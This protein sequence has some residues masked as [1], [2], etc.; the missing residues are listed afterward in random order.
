MSVTRHSWR[1]WTIG[2]VGAA[3]LGG[4]L[5]GCGS[6]SAT[7][8]PVSIRQLAIALPPQVSL[9]W[10]PPIVPVTACYDVNGGGWFGPD[11]YK[12]LVW[13]NPND[14]IDYARSLASGISVNRNDT[15]FT[16]TLNPKWHW[17]NGQ[18]VT[19]ADAA[20]D[21]QLILA[22]SGSK[23]PWAY[24]FAGS[25][26]VPGDWK[27]VHVT[28]LY[29]FSITTT[30][31]VNPAWFEHNGLGQIVPVPK[32]TWERYANP[33]QELNW[34]KSVSATWSNRVYDVYDGPYHIV[35]GV[36]S[37]YWLY[38][39]N[40]HYDG[41]HQPTFR[42][43]RYYYETSEASTFL[44]L[45]KKT[46]ELATAPSSYLGALKKMTDY[47]IVAPPLFGYQWLGLNYRRT[48]LDVGP[49]FNNLYI[50]QAL[51]MGIDQA[52]II[53]L[54]GGY[55]TPV[56]GPVPRFPHNI[57]YDYRLPDYYPYNPARGKALLESHGWHEVNGVM[58]KNG[59][60][61][62]FPILDQSGAGSP[63][64]QDE[65]EI[66]QAGWAKE[67]IKATIYLSALPANDG[68][69]WAVSGF[70]TWVYAPDF[71]P[72]GGSL[73]A[74]TGGVNLSGGDYRSAEMDHL[75][76]ATYAPGSEAQTI[77]RFYAYEK[78]AAQQLPV[79]WVPMS[80]AATG[81]LYSV[82]TNIKGF[83]AN[84]SPQEGYTPL[85]LLR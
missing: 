65:F 31:P 11:M 52:A 40:P 84:Y 13:V 85:N 39:A 81:F 59:T 28:G 1:P 74:S 34:I 58:E 15:V 43:V 50:R 19:A 79:L 67:G 30:K 4:F 49:L 5:A 80:N 66:I 12:P 69:N 72:S 6:P 53:K 2:L 27:S 56:Y 45:K 44:A 68:Q 18:P 10:F 70:G 32:S 73:F 63:S 60:K 17:S 36:N 23:A 42:T 61:L 16:V 41:V 20:Y 62:A 48:T 24:C 29:T 71:Y 35:S 7:A 82:A 64:I 57:Y 83:Q 47:R 22:A 25:G 3:A 21:V 26:G 37:E 78:Y 9:N 46:V 8:P 75:I 33:L 38:A 14:A 51:Q 76:Q 55:A 54:Y 77:Q